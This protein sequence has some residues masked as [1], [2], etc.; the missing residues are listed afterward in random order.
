MTREDVIAIIHEVIR[1]GVVKAT[2]AGASK[3]VECSIEGAEGEAT[4]PDHEMW[5]HAPLLYK[6]QV[7]AECAYFQLG[8]EKCTFVTKDR[9]WQL[10]VADGEVVLRAMGAGSPAYLQLKPSGEARLFSSAIYLGGT[11][12]QFV[13]LA[14]LVTTN[15]N[16]IKTHLDAL[17]AAL[18]LH[19]HTGVTPGILTSGPPAVPSPTPTAP[20]SVASSQTRSL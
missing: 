14:N 11:A 7:G 1:F 17:K 12:T 2:S 9:R 18:D 19:T 5:G 3:S 15:L 20:T 8:D 10:D 4:A 6:P 13:A 16:A